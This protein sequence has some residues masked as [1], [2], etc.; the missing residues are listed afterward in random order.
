MRSGAPSLSLGQSASPSG[1]LFRFW[2]VLV[3]SCRRISWGVSY[4]LSKFEV[5]GAAECGLT[6]LSA[7][8]LVA[9]T[10][11]ALPTT[12]A[13]GCESIA[14]SIAGAAAVKSV[15]AAEADSVNIEMGGDRNSPLV[16]AKRLS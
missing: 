8:P 10:S 16:E 14:G 2:L 15:E 9:P 12:E 13:A 6:P 11:N 7:S 3:C 5:P 1:K 4:K